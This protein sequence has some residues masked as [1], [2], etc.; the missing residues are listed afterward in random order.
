MP[1]GKGPNI[2][3]GTAIGGSPGKREISRAQ[4]RATAAEPVVAGDKHCTEIC[5][6]AESLDPVVQMA[7]VGIEWIGP[8]KCSSDW[9]P[10]AVS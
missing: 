6:G 10:K 7:E 4:Q 1:G 3:V 5:L 2:P 9:P 8:G